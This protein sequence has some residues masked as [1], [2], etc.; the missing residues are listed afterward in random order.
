[1][2]RARFAMRPKKTRCESGSKG[3][4]FGLTL[5]Y[6]LL[7]FHEVLS[8]CIDPMLIMRIAGCSTLDFIDPAL[9]FFEALCL[10]NLIQVR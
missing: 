4:W 1:M 10:F 7:H 2:G 5:E 3:G 6:Q 9:C 8:L